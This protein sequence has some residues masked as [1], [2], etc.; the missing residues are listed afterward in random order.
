MMKAQPE[1]Q[2]EHADS[3]VPENWVPPKVDGSGQDQL[4]LVL[5]EIECEHE[6][7]GRDVEQSSSGLPW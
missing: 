4:P 2:C 7:S 5:E 1:R 6:L 3:V